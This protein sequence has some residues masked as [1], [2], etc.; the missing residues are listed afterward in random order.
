MPVVRQESRDGIAFTVLR[1][2]STGSEAWISPDI[3][4]NCA[5][6]VTDVDGQSLEVIHLPDSLAEFRDR[7]TYFGTAVLFPFPGR[8]RG[9]RFRFGGSDYQLPI[10]EPSTG[11]AIHGCVAKR[12]WIESNVAAGAAIVEATYRIGTGR[13]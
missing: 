4:A 10:N 7:P 2:P 9:G 13:L 1:E 11:N 5:S 6:F 3:G 12:A 8:I